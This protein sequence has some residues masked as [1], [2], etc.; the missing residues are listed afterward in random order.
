[1]KIKWVV[2]RI[3][4]HSPMAPIV[5]AMTTPSPFDSNA[6]IPEESTC[7]HYNRFHKA[8]LVQNQNNVVRSIATE[9]NIVI[10]DRY[11]IMQPVLAEYQKPCDI[12]FSESGYQRIAK[13][14][15]SI[16]VSLLGLMDH[17]RVVHR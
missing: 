5:F 7:P 17:S 15:W 13:H 8:G 3:R 9:L 4:E 12:H 14:D 10:N 6:T 2:E 1:M 16:F 11:S